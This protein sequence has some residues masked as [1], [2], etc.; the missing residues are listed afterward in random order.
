MGGANYG[1][2]LFNVADNGS[3]ATRLVREIG[4]D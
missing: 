2:P 1:R 3:F 4:N